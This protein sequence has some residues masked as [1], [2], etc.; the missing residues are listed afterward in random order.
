MSFWL[1]VLPLV[2]IGGGLY[3][4]F[5]RE[6]VWRGQVRANQWR[7][8]ASERT[9]SWDQWQTTISVIAI[10]VGVLILIIGFAT[11]VPPMP[12]G[13][14]GCIPSDI[15]SSEAVKVLRID[16]GGS[17]TFDGTALTWSYDNSHTR[18]IFTGD[19]GIRSGAFFDSDKPDIFVATYTS[20]ENH[21]CF[22]RR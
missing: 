22:L 17:G 19:V 8:V 10:G 4:I 12:I 21:T 15:T 9:D 3:N 1:V 14:Y 5:A 13:E 20:G 18:I 2:M 16:E 6:S 7:G 11:R